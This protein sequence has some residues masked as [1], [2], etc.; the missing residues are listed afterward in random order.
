MFIRT[1]FWPPWL[2]ACK[3]S[4]GRIVKSLNS[5]HAISQTGA[6]VV[7]RSVTFH[8]TY[9]QKICQLLNT[10]LKEDSVFSAWSSRNLCSVL[11]L[12]RPEPRGIRERCLMH[13]NS[14]VCRAIKF[15][16]HW[17]ILNGWVRSRLP[18]FL[19]TQLNPTNDCVSHVLVFFLDLEA[20]EN[21]TIFLFQLRDRVTGQS[22]VSVKWRHGLQQPGWSQGGRSSRGRGTTSTSRP[23]PPR[24]RRTSGTT[25]TSS[26]R[27]VRPSSSLTTGGITSG[28]DME[29]R[30]LSRGGLWSFWE[31]TGS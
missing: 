21:F 14:C 19:G 13:F 1:D 5:F 15:N 16:L 6:I 22:G 29:P 25:R 4:W 20:N 3:S 8:F 23:R 17:T 27:W 9:A 11:L 7:F 26:T 30:A 18:A 10:N 2:T 12:T 28:I 24:R 31:Y